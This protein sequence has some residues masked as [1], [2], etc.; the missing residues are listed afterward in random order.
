MGEGV[1]EARTI[2]NE[3]QI[4]IIERAVQAG[5]TV[6]NVEIFYPSNSPSGGYKTAGRATVTIRFQYPAWDEINGIVYSD[7]LARSKSDAIAWVRT[8]ARGD[9]HTGTGKG[10]Y[11]FA[12]EAV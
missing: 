7:V 5:W 3:E 4:A 10:R 1:M 6:T 9:G 8:M 2:S 12:A 11:T